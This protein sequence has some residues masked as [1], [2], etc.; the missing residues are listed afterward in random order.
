MIVL[1]TH[2]WVWWVLDTGELSK[3]QVQAIADGKNDTIG[4]SAISC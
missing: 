4:I 2:V 1:D 3:A